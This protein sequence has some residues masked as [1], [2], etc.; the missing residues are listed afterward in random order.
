MARA[1]GT[2]DAD[3]IHKNFRRHLLQ[4]GSTGTVWA[5]PRNLAAT[6]SGH[7]MIPISGETENGFFRKLCAQNAA[8][9][10]HCSSAGTA[11]PRSL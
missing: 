7:P 3:P 11:P 10:L 5:P 8:K 6:P 1:E 2:A 4:G 9:G